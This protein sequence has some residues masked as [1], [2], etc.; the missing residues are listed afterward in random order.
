M[1]TKERL[2]Q[3]VDELSEAEASDA[4]RYVA[5]RSKDP[6]LRLL[7]NAPE[8]DEEIFA[9]EEAAVQEARDE[10]AAGAPTFPLE[11]VMRELGD[12]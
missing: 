1:T 9:E 5:S 2:H 11:Q 7:E 12:A 4:L 3:L 8:E 6:V 10:L